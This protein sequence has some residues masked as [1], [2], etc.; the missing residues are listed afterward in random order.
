M[1]A[2]FGARATRARRAHGARTERPRVWRMCGWM[3]IAVRRITTMPA[4]RSQSSNRKHR[5][6]YGWTGGVET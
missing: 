1:T 4:N 6:M 5:R 2:I 3:G